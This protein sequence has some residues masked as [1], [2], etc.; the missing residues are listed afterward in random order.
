[1][2]FGDRWRFGIDDSAKVDNPGSDQHPFIE[3]PDGRKLWLATDTDVALARR[4][5]EMANEFRAFANPT[6]KRGGLD[7]LR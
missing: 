4:L 1:M 5:V 7:G 3:A 2:T 6:G